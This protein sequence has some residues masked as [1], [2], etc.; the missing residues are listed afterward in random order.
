VEQFEVWV[1]YEQID[2]VKEDNDCDSVALL[3]PMGN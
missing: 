1:G 3:P 2:L